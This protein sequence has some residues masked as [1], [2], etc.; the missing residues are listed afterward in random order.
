MAAHVPP[1]GGVIK[2]AAGVH[3]PERQVQP[4]Q[5]VNG[6]FPAALLFGEVDVPVEEGG[7]EI[8]AQS[9]AEK[10]CEAMKTMKRDLVGAVDERVLAVDD[11]GLR[12]VFAQ[13][14]EMR[15]VF[16]KLRTGGPDIGKKPSGMAAVQIADGGGQHDQ[17]AG[18]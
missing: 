9:R 5:L 10:F 14:R 4:G 7:P 3:D 2:F 12:V 17:I 6:G 15:V 13:R 8:Q 1:L 11:L 18:R 16:P